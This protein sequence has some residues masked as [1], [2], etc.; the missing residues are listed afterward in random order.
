MTENST[1]A[2]TGLALLAE[3][4]DKLAQM[5]EVAK[6]VEAA[7]KGHAAALEPKF[8]G[9]RVIAIIGEDGECRLFNPREGNEMTGKL[10]AIE[11]ALAEA[12]PP[13]SVLDGEAVAFAVEDDRLVQKWGKAASVLGSGTAKAALASG[14]ITFV[15]FDLLAHGG[16]DARGL[17]YEKRRSLL[18]T[19]FEAADFGTAQIILVPQLA[20]TEASHGTLI[21]AG[22]EGSV[23]KH[24]DAT[25][26][27]GK[28]GKGWSKVKPVATVDAIITGY[29][30][31]ENG[32][33]GYIGAVT[34][35][36]YDDD[37]ILVPRGKC[38]GM[39]WDV[40]KDLTANREANLNRVIEVAHEGTF[41]P[42]KEHP[43][44]AFRFPRFKRFRD[45]KPAAAVVLHDS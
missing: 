21:E 12:L 9:W 7:A 6:S 28:R 35:G 25:Y 43:L 34:F 33:A 38:S 26:A 31:G 41:P 42:S 23:V 22:Y 4:R 32:F 1:E 36:Q 10:P 30:E 20:A 24:L 45:D 40:R 18:K 16:H 37:G 19:L 3:P 2:A 13:G 17:S 27:S 44:G 5:P 39:D 15:A 11:S 29:T 8:D 14:A